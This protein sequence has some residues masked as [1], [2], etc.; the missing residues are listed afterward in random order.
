MILRIHENEC[1]HVQSELTGGELAV[2]QFS[3]RG[4]LLI[5]LVIL[6]LEVNVF[7]HI[8]FLKMVQNLSS[9]AGFGYFSYL[10]ANQIKNF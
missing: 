8:I 3:F 6:Q 9:N 5:S 4:S 2:V 10:N 7:L 1:F